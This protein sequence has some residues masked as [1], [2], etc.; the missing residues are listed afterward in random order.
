MCRYSV[1]SWTVR[2]RFDVFVPSGPSSGSWPHMSW[3]QVVIM[4]SALSG[5]LAIQRPSSS[6]ASVERFQH[7]EG[8]GALLVW[9]KGLTRL[10]A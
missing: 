3:P 2:D 8:A 5:L 4:M 1:L 6:A 7:P 9:G 10:K